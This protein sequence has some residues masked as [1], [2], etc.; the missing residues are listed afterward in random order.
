MDPAA[1][2]A[3]MGAFQD[4]TTY[5]TTSSHWW[6]ERGILHRSFEHLRLSGAA[7]LAAGIVAIPSA[8]VLGHVKRGGFLAQSIVNIGRAVPSFAILVLMLP[9]SLNYGFGLGFWPTFVALVPLAIPPMFT[10]AYVGV[11]DV[12]PN[13]V[14]ASRAMGMG[15]S[16]VLFRVEAPV[17]RPLILTGLRVA[18]V[19]V[20]ATA[21]LGAFVGFNGLGSYIYEGFSQQ[22]DGK[23]L[24]GAVGVALLAFLTELVFSFV[25]RRATPWQSP[26]RSSDALPLDDVLSTKG[27]LQ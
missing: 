13:I 1:G 27:S 16:Q 7:V 14:E 20:V 4:F 22:D 8:L 25:V 9:L 12:D 19:Q 6:G 2:S 15:G 3:L 23:L 18:A 5:V 10:N 11:R 26:T 21:T 17:A 24:T